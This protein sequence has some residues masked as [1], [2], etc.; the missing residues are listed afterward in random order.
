MVEDGETRS[1]DCENALASEHEFNLLEMLLMKFCSIGNKSSFQTDAMPVL[2]KQSN[3]VACVDY[4]RK[5]CPYKSL[6]TR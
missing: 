1:Q 5:F 2:L 6:N 3:H 4:V